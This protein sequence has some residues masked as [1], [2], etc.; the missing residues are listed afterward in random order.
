MSIRQAV[1]M[2]CLSKPS[3]PLFKSALALAA[4]LMAA[5]G[6]SS[7]GQEPDAPQADSGDTTPPVITLNGDSPLLLE[8]GDPYVEPGATAEDDVDGP[9]EV[10]IE[11]D[12]GETPGDYAVDYSASDSAG[13]SAT[14][15]RIVTVVPRPDTGVLGRRPEEIL[16]QLT[17][18]QKAA[19]LIQAEIS[20][21]SFEDIRRFGIGS[22]LNGG[23]SYPEGRRAATVDEWRDY[24]SK[25]RD[26]SLDTASGGAGIPIVW[27]TDAVHGHNNV[28]GAT[29]YP[30]NIG[31]GATRNPE[32]IRAIGEA[33]A[34]AVA[35]TGI[36]WIFGPTVA[37]AQDLRWG[38]SY[39]S[40]SDDSELVSR[41]AYQLV[42]GIQSR[43]L[44]ATAK[45][46]IGDGGTDR[47]IDQGNTT[48][49]DD[50]L[51][52][53]HGSGFEGA[54]AADVLSVMATFNSVMGEKV[55]G[56]SRILTDLL[57]S[58]LKFQG[59][60][61]SDWNGIAQVSGCSNAQC[62]QAFNAGIDMSMTPQDWQSLLDNLVTNVERGEISEARL[63]EAVLRVLRFKERL[64]LL[65]ASYEIGRGI[66]TSTVGNSEHRQL[67]RRAVRE[68]L[69]LLKNNDAALP[70]RPT[71]KILLLGAAADSLPH[72]A[73]GWSV[74]W[75]GTGTSNADFPGGTTIKGALEA[76]LADGGGMLH[77]SASGSPSD[78][79]DP[80]AVIVV[81]AE[82]PYAE[83]AGDRP[84]L[85]WAGSRSTP[86]ETAQQWREKGVPV[87]TLFLTGRP[88][89]INPE[90]NQSDAVITAWLP[91][92]EAAGI[93]DVLMTDAS[94]AIQH[95]FTGT[96][97]FPWPGGA[98]HPA[99][100]SLAVEAALF[101]R[102]YGLSYDDDT[103]IAALSENPRNAESGLVPG[104]DPDSNT[105]SDLPDTLW[106]FQNGDIAPRWDRGIGAF[107]EA[108][109][110][111]V[112]E[113]D[114]GAACPSIDWQVVSDT[115]RGDVLEIS[116]PD[117]AAF[118]G[119][120]LES[121]SGTDLSSYDTVSFELLHL[122]GDN[123][124]AMKLD[125]FYPCTSG[126]LL[127]E[128]PQTGWQSIDISLDQLE[129]QGLDRSNVNTGLVIWATAHSGNRFRIDD[130][131][132]V[133][134]AP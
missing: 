5:C 4:L 12:V 102:G 35:A 46:F 71:Q 94:G 27:G 8:E 121:F 99:D 110:W 37:Q 67:A 85:D 65:S 95:N 98:V 32:L 128:R 129:A 109:G 74:T 17:L 122:E 130:V 20:N 75:Q 126:D 34:A 68:S 28:R 108:I 31:L 3:Q 51:M 52:A 50:T 103:A 114:G 44:A 22:V 16:E 26:A 82:D 10:V 88:L 60:V 101:P 119:L 118:A 77:Y 11:G 127:L 42:E 55:H 113:N 7:G 125:C 92:T 134:D 81:L 115:E 72:Q 2:N 96:L 47:G 84:D 70:L 62:P 21:I 59:L 83:G 124:Y 132:F 86:L 91:G 112:C 25:L 38:R 23:G 48:L 104:S 100:S 24:A 43:G 57:R 80:D 36:D 56:S 116:Y 89:W 63:D 33:T 106:V 79:I 93:T 66:P 41:Y 105:G 123:Q 40:Y 15:Q 54:I 73:G 9:V 64:G 90:I 19:Q 30:H 1:A 49:D 120:F 61:V 53:V 76:A 87:I 97:P 6:G 133:R 107:D 117:D 39:E 13:N 111:G 18:T 69:V 29:L 45:H 78:D 58:Q 131:R 14:I